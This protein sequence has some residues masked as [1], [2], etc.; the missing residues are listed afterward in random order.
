MK[1]T[2]IGWTRTSNIEGFQ[3]GTYDV[4]SFWRRGPDKEVWSNIPIYTEPN[5]NQPFGYTTNYNEYMNGTH[6][7]IACWPTNKANSI[8]LYL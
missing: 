4:I 3:A 5:N 6:D 7:V 2:P 1:R 8:P